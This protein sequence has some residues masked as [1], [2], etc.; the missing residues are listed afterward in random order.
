MASLRFCPALS[1]GEA[2]ER[3]FSL[4]GGPSQT[5]RGEKRAL[6]ALA[7]SLQLDVDLAKTNAA[8][9][10]DISA[11]LGIQWHTIFENK[12]KVNLRGLNALLQGAADAKRRGSL[13][14]LE[15]ARPKVLAGPEWA[16]FA[17][18]KSKIEAVNRISALTE[19]GP[20]FLGPGSK[21]RKSVLINLAQKLASDIDTSKSK[22]KLGA[23]LAHHFGMQWSPTCSST[24]ET[25]SLEGLN[26]LLAGAERR[27][28][29]LG[30]T[31]EI[32]FATPREEAEALTQALRNGWAAQRLPDGR[33]TV[34]WDAKQCI[35]FM[36]EEDIR[37]ARD[38]QWQ[39][40]Y[41][42]AMGIRILN[43]EFAPPS[44]P[45]QQWYDN[46]PFDYARNFLWDFKAKAIAQD[47]NGVI[48]PKS[49]DTQLNAAS[50]T[51][52]AIADQGLGFLVVSGVG[53]MDSDLE[54]ENW[55]RKLKK[56]KP[57]LANSGRHTFMKKRFELESIDAYFFPNTLALDQAKLV[58]VL[59]VKRQG[60][61]PR[62]RSGE[63]G[64]DRGDKMHMDV[65]GARDSDFHLASAA[66]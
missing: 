54:V 63:A 19:S 38:N 2:K 61:Q 24:G 62:K 11:A 26:L 17:P 40:W 5:A 64:D 65:R 39:G 4:T 56:K 60:R 7:E 23:D 46:T 6:V 28:G 58:G 41:W 34:I 27:L 53:V 21:E 12:T 22:S 66:W 59:K 33:R 3:I 32:L 48:K 44:V 57:A 14:R 49:A 20:E 1:V 50:A 25:I 51:E 8:L 18:A 29:V 37:G 43:K 15:S 52:M 45:R 31:S 16:G 42:E 36:L 35:K 30:T 10:K 55:Q 13:Q 47:L 9:G